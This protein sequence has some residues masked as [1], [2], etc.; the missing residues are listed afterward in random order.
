MT[1][2]IRV[3]REDLRPPA[4]PPKRHLISIRDLTRDDVER[5][6]ATARTFARSLEREVKK[7]P[8]LKGRLVV[9]VFYESSTRTSSSF[10]LAAKRLSADTMSMKSAGSS[11]DK[12]ESLKD[13]AIT[14]G[15]YDPTTRTGPAICLRC[16]LAR[17]LPDADW[18]EDA[19]PILYMPGVGKADLRA[20]ETCSHALQP[21]AELQYRGVLWVQRANSKDWTIEAFLTSARGGLDIKVARRGVI[22]SEQEQ[23]LAYETG[24]SREDAAAFINSYRNTYAGVTQFMEGVRHHAQLYGQVS[25]LLGRVRSLPEIHSNHPGLRQAA[26]RAAIN[27]PVQGTAADIIKKAMIDVSN[28]IDDRGLR[29]R[30]VSQ[31]VAERDCV[32][33]SVGEGKLLAASLDER[34]PRFG[35]LRRLY[36]DL[37]EIF[38]GAVFLSQQH[39][40]LPERGQDLRVFDLRFAQQSQRFLRFLSASHP[41]LAQCAQRLDSNCVGILPHVLSE[42]AFGLR[43]IPLGVVGVSQP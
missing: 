10:E 33:R 23:R 4:P 8:T 25:T 6:L 1:A 35:S 43:V 34:D 40:R 26:E 41:G 22:V 7:L 16:M 18:P 38:C 36:D 39:M 9:N 17:T 19:T 30:H 29:I 42:L 28:S 27:M 31:Q 14:L 5:L 12:G 11:V 13:T 24:L 20:V 21:L 15:A 3:M 2:D 32:E 37:L